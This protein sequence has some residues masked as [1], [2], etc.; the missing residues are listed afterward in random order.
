MRL[1]SIETSELRGSVALLCEG[2]VDHELALSSKFRSAQALAPA[3]AE[4]LAAEGWA[5]GHLEGIAVGIGPGSFTGLRVGIATAKTLAWALQ[6]PTA[7]VGTLQAIAAQAAVDLAA[8]SVSP[9][10]RI[11][12][13]SN[14]Y[15]KQVFTAT[16]EFHEDLSSTEISPPT[17]MDLQQWANQVMEP[18]WVTGPALKLLTPNHLEALS[19]QLIDT[20]QWAPTAAMIGRLGHRKF[21]NSEALEPSQL[22]PEYGRVSAAEEKR[23]EKK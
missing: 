13:A 19:T 5:A 14:A 1:L 20:K 16:Y 23:P 18:A 21:Q 6:I 8:K 10:W 12:A 3:I 7:P 15:R 9:P 17:T 22:L 4:V 2:R 11:V